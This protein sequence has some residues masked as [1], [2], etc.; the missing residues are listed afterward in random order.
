MRARPSG[1]RLVLREQYLLAPALRADEAN[2]RAGAPATGGA[3]VDFGLT[4]GQRELRDARGRVRGRGA[5][6]AGG[7]GRAGAAGGCRRTSGDGC[8]DEARERGLDSATT[9]SSWADAAGTTSS[10]CWCTRSW[11]ATPTRSG[12]TWPA[13]T[14]CCPE[15]TPEQIERYLQPTL[16]GERADAYAVTEGG[17]GSDAGAIAGRAEETAGGWRLHAEKWFVTTGDVADYYIV[18]VN[19]E[20]RRASCC[21]RCSW[22]T[23]TGPGS[24]SSTTRRSRTTTRTGTRPSASTVELPADAVLGGAGDGRAM[25]TSCRTSGSSRSGSTSPPAVWARCGGCSTRRSGWSLEREQFG[26]RIFDFQG[27]SFPLADSAA[28]LPGGAAAGLPRGLRWPTTRRPTASWCTHRASDGEAVRERG[29]LPLRRPLRAGLRRPRLH[30]HEHRR[31]LPARAA[32]RPHLGGH[33]RDPA[34]DRRPRPGAARRRDA[35]RRHRLSHAHERL[36]TTVTAA[37]ADV[38]F[39]SGYHSC[40]AGAIRATRRSTCHDRRLEVTAGGLEP[41]SNARV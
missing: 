5:D 1:W 33:Q 16:R 28:G 22:S 31:A 12:G 6:P 27:V 15:G 24:R 3:G 32:G 34:A 21:R 36:H 10:R 4:E 35:A 19:V 23:A 8:K 37:A 39:D 7:D 11:A 40:R 13:A 30:A 14:T 25:G 17:A 2:D 38:G 26:S 41:D 20:R 29:G 9:R 18:M